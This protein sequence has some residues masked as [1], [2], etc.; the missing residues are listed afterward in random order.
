MPSP[1]TLLGAAVAAAS[2]LATPGA[3]AQRLDRQPCALYGADYPAPTAPAAQAAFR[4]A[5]ASL[6]AQLDAALERPVFGGQQQLDAESTAYAVEVFSLHSDTAVFSHAFTPAAMSSAQKQSSSSTASDADAEL[7]PDSVVRIGSISKLWTVY[8]YLIAAGDESWNRPVTDFVPELAALAAAQQTTTGAASDVDVVRWSDVTVGALASQMAGVARDSAW[9][10]LLAEMLSSLGVADQGGDKHSTCGGAQ[11]A[12]IP[13][14]R[15][16][17]FEDYP[18]QHPVVSPFLTPVYSN[19]A[20][21]ILSYALENI[22]NTS[23]PDLFNR[24]L[25]APLGLR[26]THYTVP[27]S[28]AGGFVPYGNT[29]ASWWAADLRDETV[30]GGY[31]SSVRDANVVARA[32]L[33]FELLPPALTR[34]WMAPVAFTSDA[35]FLVGAPWEILRAP[36]TSTS[37]LS[38][39]SSSSPSSSSSSDTTTTA[40]AG[41]GP[42][43]YMY[44]KSGDLGQYAGQTVLLPEL[45]AGFTVLAAGDAATATARV[46]ADLVATAAVPALRAAARAEARAAYAGRYADRASNSSLAVSVDENGSGYG[47]RV[48]S[49]T[50]AGADVLALLAQLKGVNASNGE[51]LEVHLYPTGLTSSVST[52]SGNGTGNSTTAGG[53]TARTVAWRAVFEVLPAAYDAGAFSAN[54]AT[55][56]AV[57]SYTYGGVGLDEFLFTVVD[58]DSAAAGGSRAV[59]VSP[60]V[61]GLE[62]ARADGG[63]GGGSGSSSLRKLARMMRT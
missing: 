2:L 40:A 25:V 34:R 6:T 43:Q 60:R 7:G 5:T 12:D 26:A 53:A 46:V 36:T 39:S 58:D 33:A 20:Y 23:M 56:G 8:L 16:A 38:S 15:T 10:P 62:L 59:D 19:A 13:C 41:A 14:N 32:V 63:V 9:S 22:T 51:A 17:F 27:A 30:A 1:L 18:T 47:L 48:T 45:D 55:W 42:L 49:Y 37:S 61:L 31:F 24:A 29:T 4:Q 35:D 52:R 21:Q 28:T 11:W 54:C 3:S 50:A 44:T 57:D